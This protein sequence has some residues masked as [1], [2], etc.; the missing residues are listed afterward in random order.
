ME[1]LRTI[2]QILFEVTKIITKFLKSHIRSTSCIEINTLFA[3]FNNEGLG[4]FEFRRNR[5]IL[6]GMGAG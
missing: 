1:F 2:F 6:N 3:I 4:T 5:S